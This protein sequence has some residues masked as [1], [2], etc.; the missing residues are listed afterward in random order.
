LEA[1][2]PEGKKGKKKE[3]GTGGPRVSWDLLFRNVEVVARRKK[4]GGV[5]R[6]VNPCANYE[7][8]AWVFLKKLFFSGPKP[9]GTAL[10]KREL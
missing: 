8:K 6:V 1:G 10:G 5:N 4:G 9:L 7:K 2:P 3:N